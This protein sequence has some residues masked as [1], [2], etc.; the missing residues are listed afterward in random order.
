MRSYGFRVL[1]STNPAEVLRR[2]WASPTFEVHGLVG[3]YTGP[4]V[5]TVVPGY[6]ELKVSMRLVPHQRPEKI[7]GLLRRFVRS[8]NPL[9][10]V[11]AAGM[12]Q[13]YRGV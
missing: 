4:G 1:R 8:R 2:I 10:K 3:G 5:K 6:A 7:L 12:L 13:P 9:V 11:E